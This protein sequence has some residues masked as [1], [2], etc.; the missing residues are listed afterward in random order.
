[1]PPSATILFLAEAES[2][3]AVLAA[4]LL[5]LASADRFRTA[6]VTADAPREP[7]M[8]VRHI[9]AENMMPHWWLPSPARLADLADP[10]RA[11]DLVAVLDQSLIPLARQAAPRACVSYW[12]FPATPR[13]AFDD[14]SAIFDWRCLYAAIARRTGLLASLSPDALGT[15]HANPVSVG[16]SLRLHGM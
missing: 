2:S 11:A 16:R 12:A 15:L 7:H 4:H 9:L 1:M 3:V 10:L 6:A 5:A 13:V 8:L 14:V